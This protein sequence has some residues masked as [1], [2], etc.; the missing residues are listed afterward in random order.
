MIKFEC[1]APACGKRIGVDDA[2]AGR[3]VRCPKCGEPA[4]VPD[5]PPAPQ[6]SPEEP[7]GGGLADLAALDADGPLELQEVAAPEVKTNRAPAP[8]TPTGGPPPPPAGE[9]K[10]CPKC[11]A[12]AAASAKI[13]VSCGHGFKG[14]SAGNRM[15]TRKAGVLA[16]RSGVALVGGLVTALLCG[17]VWAMIAKLTG[18]EFGFMAPLLGGGTGLATALIAQQQS[19]LVGIGAVVTAIAG[20]VAAKAMIAW[21]VILPMVAGFVAGEFGDDAMRAGYVA[22]RLETEGK[23]TEPMWEALHFPEDATE[24]DRAALDGAVAT[25]IADNG[26]P[27]PNP[28]AREEAV[29]GRLQE[30]GLVTEETADRWFEDE[31]DAEERRRLDLLIA[32]NVAAEGEPEVVTAEEALDELLSPEVTGLIALAGALSWF[33]LLWVPLMCF[34]AYKTGNGD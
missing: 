21:L 8:P 30:G 28:W 2:A 34:A 27:G 22:T 10:A 20:W 31:L 24:A 12:P 6:V 32:Q 13:C 11:D 3:R 33:D 25:W 14:L 23:M 26:D 17:F 29:I 9:T 18:R 15:K 4:R 1:P 7:A 5:A 19:V 16:G